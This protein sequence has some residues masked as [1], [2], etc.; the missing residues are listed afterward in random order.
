MA[1]IP[2][3]LSVAVAAGLIGT[4]FL[5]SLLSAALGLGGGVILLAVLAALLPPAALIP[6]HGL[7]QLGFNASRVAIMPRDVRWGALAPFA[8][9]SLVGA[10]VGGAVVVDLPGHWVRVG[11]GLFI[12]WSVVAT[13]PAIF[14]R[15]ALPTGLLSTFLSMFFG[16][17]GPFVAAYIRTLR[18]E[19]MNVVATHAAFMTVQ[20]TLK[21]VAF[22][23]FGF[24]FGPWLALIA[25]MLAAGFLGTV[26][27]KRVLVRLP[28]ARFQF[29]LKAILIAMALNL[30]WQGVRTALHG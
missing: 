19:R 16:A 6:V 28:E 29:A 5:T 2:E 21:V 9:G 8:L 3:G 12:L 26:A 7:V 23:L 1:L 13:P 11:V 17:T 27:G 20:H 15:A 25:A 18:L 14:R 22:G 10:A 4:S 30:I 24:A